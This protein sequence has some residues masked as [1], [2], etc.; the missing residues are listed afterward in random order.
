MLSFRGDAHKFYVKLK[1]SNHTHLRYDQNRELKEIREIQDFYETIETK[2]LID[3]YYKMVKEKNGSGI[4]P[5][6]VSAGPWLLFIFSKQLQEFL[7]KD[8]SMLWLTFIILY[9]TILSLSVMLHFHE[10]AWASLHIEV[11]QDI[12]KARGIEK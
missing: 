12:L 1:N 11:I 2:T 6:F 7:F 10:K 4:I 9:V 8:G 3:I 5:I